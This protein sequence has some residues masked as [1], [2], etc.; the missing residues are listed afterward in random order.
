MP[1][2]L[3][4]TTIAELST[5]HAADEVSSVTPLKLSHLPPIKVEIR[6]PPLYPIHEPPEIIRLEATVGSE[7][8]QWLDKPYRVEIEHRL[9]NMWSEDKELAGEGS[10]VIWRWWEWIGSGECLLDLGLL[11]D[12]VLRYVPPASCQEM[13]D[14]DRLRPVGETPMSTFYTALKTY[15][16]SQM[17]SDFEKT[18]FSCG[19]CLEDRKGKSCIQM[20]GCGCVLCV[21]SSSSS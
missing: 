10:G 17:Q 21:P 9:E 2:T 16:A 13:A 15:N 8:D 11:K 7:A 12:D 14:K 5:S 19:I 4:E 1:I 18:A 3:S 20:P 6:I